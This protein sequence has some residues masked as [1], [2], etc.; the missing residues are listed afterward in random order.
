MTGRRSQRKGY[1]VEN[2]IVNLHKDAGIEATR[3]PLSGATGYR[4][5]VGDV[6]V[7][8]FP[9][10]ELIP[11][12]IKARANGEGF[13]TLERWMGNH[14]V[15]FLKRNRQKPMVVISWDLWIETLK[16]MKGEENGDDEL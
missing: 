8:V 2:A 10:G 6:D 14:E 16:R 15:M 1:V 3:V 11:C 5:N 7:R 13:T 12:E 9:D 4:G